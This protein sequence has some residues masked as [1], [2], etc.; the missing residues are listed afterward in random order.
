MEHSQICTGHAAVIAR[1]SHVFA[2]REDPK[3]AET[4]PMGDDLGSEAAGAGAP[5]ARKLPIGEVV[6]V[7]GKG[8]VADRGKYN[9]WLYV[10]YG[11]TRQKVHDIHVP[12]IIQA[13][14]V[15]SLYSAV[16]DEHWFPFHK[17]ARKGKRKR[18]FYKTKKK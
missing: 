15:I 14:L 6:P 7:L 18:R 9:G 11:W 16:I 1:L 4:A 5:R 13:V 12:A 3:C 2:G 8:R 17:P 10:L